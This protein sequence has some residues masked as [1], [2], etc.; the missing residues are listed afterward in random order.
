MKNQISTLLRSYKATIAYIMTIVIVNM[1]YSSIPFWHLL[2]QEVSIGDFMVGFVFIFRDFTQ[3]EIK[4]NVLYAMVIGGS[5]SFLLANKTV[6]YASII[7][8]LVGETIDWLIF[9]FTKKP[10]SQ[11]LLWSSLVSA[12][13]DSILFLLLIAHF[14]WLEFT[15]M[16]L[17]KFAGVLFVWGCWK[18]RSDQDMPALV[19]S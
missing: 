12:P 9:T 19:P 15:I 8:F 1:L 3:R 2:G 4:H 13:P 18:L 17:A 6:A 11:R 14:S 10:L 7:A 16:T 5:L